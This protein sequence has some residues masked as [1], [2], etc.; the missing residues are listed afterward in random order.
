[1]PA[2]IIGTK[3]AEH[4]K[5][6]A[7]LGADCDGWHLAETPDLSIIEELMP[8]GTIEVRHSHAHARQFF[9]VLEGEST[10]EVEHHLFVLRP[11]EG[12]EFR[13]LQSLIAV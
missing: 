6:G 11:G 4:Y 13:A 2:Q 12:I 7:P 8:A 3:S 10:L 1:L 5:W 9:Y